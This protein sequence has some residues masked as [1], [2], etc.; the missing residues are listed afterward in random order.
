MPPPLA[1]PLPISTQ[2]DVA[3]SKRAAQ[4]ADWPPP[5]GVCCH[6]AIWVTSSVVPSENVP[7]ATKALPLAPSFGSPL[8][9]LTQFVPSNRLTR[10]RVKLIDPSPLPL[11]SAQ[12]ILGRKSSTT[13]MPG[14]WRNL[15]I[16]NAWLALTPPGAPSPVP[17]GP[18]GMGGPVANHS[19]PFHRIP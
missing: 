12:M 3:G 18:L 11:P 10:T 1:E 15:S 8:S 7:M 6:V 9:I 5:L 2:D 13:S 16:E 17:M 14:A 4:T 19:A